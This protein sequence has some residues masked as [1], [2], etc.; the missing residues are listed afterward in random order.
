MTTRLAICIPAKETLYTEFSV[1][2]Y[3]L[4]KFNWE[5]NI[6]CELFINTG[7][8]LSHQREASVLNAQKYQ[9]THILWLDSDMIFPKN[10]AKKLLDHNLKIVCANYI[11]RRPP[12]YF[13]GRTND[14]FDKDGNWNQEPNLYNTNDVLTEVNYIGMGC[15]LTDIEV[16]HTIPRPWFE[17]KKH[18]KSHEYIVEDANFCQL[19]RQFGYKIVVDNALTKQIKHIGIFAVD[20]NADIDGSFNNQY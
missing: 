13:I 7:T 17:I 14:V 11:T 16:F 18:P 12:H 15:M 3:Q 9:A 20:S 4:L 1:R 2:L 8:A 10:T 6:Q 19:A 5:N